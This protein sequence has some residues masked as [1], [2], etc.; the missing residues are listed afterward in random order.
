MT[1]PTHLLERARRAPDLDLCA[2]PGSTAVVAFGD[3][4]QARVA[5]LGINPSSAEFLDTSGVLLAGDQRRLATLDSLGVTRH[6]AL[7]LEHAEA[8]VDDSARYFDRRPYHWFTPLD[9]ILREA[10][11]ATYHDRSACHLDLVQVATSP[12]WGALPADIQDD[13]VRADVPFLRQQL[14]ETPFDIVVVNGQ[15]VR[16]AVERAGLVRWQHVHTLD[17]PPKADLF[18]GHTGSTL[19]VAWT[20]N[21]QSQHGALAH[22]D[23]LARLLASEVGPKR[24]TCGGTA[25]PLPIGQA[26]RR[27]T[28]PQPAITTTAGDD[29][30]PMPRGL[31]FTSKSELVGY[32]A[33]WLD[34]SSHDTIG[35]VG[36]YGGSTWATIDS[37]VGVIGLNRDTT[38]SAIE[39]FVASARNGLSYDWLA[40][41][42]R[43]G[44]INKVLFCEDRTPGWFAYLREPLD[45][46]T[47]LGHGLPSATTSAQRRP[48]SPDR[49]TEPAEA[50]TPV[51]AREP[52]WSTT[53]T[54]G[55]SAGVAVATSIPH[56]D[57]APATAA[58]TGEAAIVQ[59]PHPGG[60]HVPSGSHMGW[61]LGS[62]ARKFLAATGTRIDADGRAHDGPLA[63]W[64]EWEAPSHVI[65]RWDRR[66]ALPTVLHDPYWTRNAPDRERQ[67]TDPWVFGDTFIYSNCKQ[68]TPADAPSA[69]QSLPVG[70]LILF[71]SARAGEFV[72]DT[73]FVVGEAAGRYWP[74]GPDTASE[75]E[76]EDAFRTCTIESLARLPARYAHARFALFR[77][78]TP[79]A[80]VGGI[81]SFTPCVPL[82]AGSPRFV[83][84]PIRLDGLINP[85]SAQSPS[86]AKSRHRPAD[87]QQAWD[88]VVDQVLAAGLD[89][90]VR[91][92]TPPE[93]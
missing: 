29:S 22:S 3:P 32:L 21:L 28:T 23:D 15:S 50:A 4:V 45:S 56:P 10:L 16:S 59:F 34:R 74:M 83:R 63:F 93:K 84:P 88:D 19:W 7:T 46:E 76:V 66:A 81:Y 80:P 38:R 18:V 25:A 30:G 65:R 14:V 31:H 58:P 86:G 20:C 91:L 75:V 55:P 48:S 60:E 6:D 42:N 69:L 1:W 11:G 71:G 12:L 85:R 13:L 47:R 90:A 2:V 79:E 68:L 62:H 33:S 9:D 87:V 70:S 5:T 64:G 82:G 24:P 17:G 44:R 77:G 92:D 43:K 73:V 61:N 53:S 89:L 57:T 72:L 35:D 52:S 36:T 39:S 67:N 40:V 41:A 78:A 37:E 51:T 49:P 26:T 54:A 8:I 27:R